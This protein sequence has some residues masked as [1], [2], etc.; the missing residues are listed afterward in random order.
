MNTP[1]DLQRKQEKVI[2]CDR[3]Y[4]PGRWWQW[5]A[6]PGSSGPVQLVLPCFVRGD[7]RN[8]LVV[9]GNTYG[10]ISAKSEYR[11]PLLHNP[12]EFIFFEDFD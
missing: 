6:A 4:G 9:S 1:E 10:I 3:E 7:C 2:N 12:D 5:N 8:R 11:L